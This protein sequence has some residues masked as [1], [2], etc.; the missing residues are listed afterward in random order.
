MQEELLYLIKSMEENG[1][2]V[3]F[4]SSFLP[5]ELKDIDSQLTSYLCSG[6]IAPIHKPDFQLRLEII[7]KKARFYEINIPDTVSKFVASKIKTDIRQLE[8][9]IKKIWP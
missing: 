9:C 6:L 4:S 2:L 3:I 1:K 7:K 8:S 5:K